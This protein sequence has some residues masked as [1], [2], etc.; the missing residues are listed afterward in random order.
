MADRQPEAAVAEEESAISVM[1]RGLRT[2][3][4]LVQGLFATALIGVVVAVG[5]I[6]VPIVIQLALDRGG[7]T[8]GDVDTGTVLQ[9]VLLGFAVIATTEALALIA[10]RRMI[11]RAEASLRRLRVLAFEHVHRQ[12]LAV[13]N[14]QAT[15]VMISRVTSDVD[16]LSRFADWGLFVW[17]V[18]PIVVIGVFVAMAVY[19]WQLALV[20]LLAFTPVFGAMRWVR[21]RMSRAHEERRTA[22]GDLL[23]AFNEAL[24]GAEVV[25]A[26]N[27]QHRTQRRLDTVSETR[28]RKGLRANFYMAGVYVVGDLIGAVMLALVLL[29]GV[30]QREALDL[31]SGELV[32]I[33]FLITLLLT[34]I[35]E[36]GETINNAQEAVAGWRKVLNLLDEPIEDLDPASGADLPSGP[37]SIDSHSV[38][39]DYGD[40]VPVLRDV[41]VSIPAGQR[42]AIVGETGSGKST[43][44]R[45]MCR[46]ADPV[47]GDMLIGGVPLTEVSGAARHAAVRMVPQDGFLFD[48]TIRENISYGRRDATEADID[49]AIA[50]LNLG[51][52][53]AGLPLGLDTPVGERGS[54][55]SVGERQLVSFARAAVADPGILILDEATSSVDPQTD[56]QLTR[57]LD[58]LAEGR[59]VVSIAH[60]LS[61][62]ESAD[63]VLVFADGELI[64]HGGHD[65]LVARGGRYAALFAAWT[66]DTATR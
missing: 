34:P 41:T 62:A 58:R 5:Q 47:A 46:L 37:L 8:S 24:T 21:K 61:T 30:T 36:L 38:H 27:A 42:V 17:V 28:Y 14:E 65:E 18:E 26:Y 63:L 4:E 55:L 64:E 49:Q 20:A 15:G 23:G 44:A 25:R 19:S 48:T 29:V 59:T 7:L 50:L 12:S 45:L 33:L 31:S 52:W 56:L 51:P 3:P 2:T 13:H 16:S 57:A 40:G 53:V 6:S 10:K 1:R 66:A 39:F 35:A 54:S 60:R 32:A 43:F 22:I 9:L 11:V